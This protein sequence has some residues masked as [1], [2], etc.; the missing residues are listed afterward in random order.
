MSQS[1]DRYRE[2]CDAF[3]WQVPP[4]FNIGWECCGRWAREHDRVALHYEDDAGR[5]GGE[6][7]DRNRIGRQDFAPLLTFASHSCARLTIMPMSE[8]MAIHVNP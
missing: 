8:L 7:Q 1:Q 4:R 3:H 2:I 5:T 6:M